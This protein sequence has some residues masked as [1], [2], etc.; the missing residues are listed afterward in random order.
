M[1]TARDVRAREQL[2]WGS[3]SGDSNE[4]ILG[5]RVEKWDRSEVSKRSRSIIWEKNQASQ[6]RKGMPCL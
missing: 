2:L 1:Q 6:H 3:D 5:L 4:Q